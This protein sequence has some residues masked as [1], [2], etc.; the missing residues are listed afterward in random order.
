VVNS[1]L[2]HISK[3]SGLFGFCTIGL[4]A[5]PVRY[6][7]IN[8]VSPLRPKNIGE[9]KNSSIKPKNI[10]PQ[11]LRRTAFLREISVLGWVN[12]QGMFWLLLIFFVGL[13]YLYY[14]YTAVANKKIFFKSSLFLSIIGSIALLLVSIGIVNVVNVKSADVLSTMA[15]DSLELANVDT[16]ESLWSRGPAYS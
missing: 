3:S 4:T 11:N 15:S 2:P 5:S 8:V 12:R 9:S 7:I 13:S 14:R 16:T 10:N 1:H 6:I